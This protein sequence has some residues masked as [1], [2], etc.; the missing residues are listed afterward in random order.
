MLFVLP[1]SPRWLASHG[2]HLESLQVLANVHAHGDVLD[3]FVQAQYGEIRESV[4]SF[5]C[6]FG[7]HGNAGTDASR[8][9]NP[10]RAIIVENELELGFKSIFKLKY[11]KRIFL[12]CRVQAWCQLSGINA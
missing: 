6:G 7:E 3:P 8:T 2:R 1:E 12:G 4:A 11:L 10:R 9:P 5:S